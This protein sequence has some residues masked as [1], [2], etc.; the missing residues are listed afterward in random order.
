M[1][2]VTLFLLGFFCSMAM[3]AGEVTKLE[4]IQVAQQYVIQTSPHQGKATVGSSDVVYTQMMPGTDSAA[5]YIVNVGDNA[6]VLV[7]AD[8]VAQQV[9]GYS[10]N[11]NF[12]VKA[13]GSIELP[14]HIKGFLE[15]LA[16][17]VK[18]AVNDSGRTKA[19]VRQASRRAA[20]L[21]ESVDPLIT[22]TWDQGQYYN[23]L[24][25]LCTRL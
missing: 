20:N 17:Q 19:V 22:T 13:D 25:Y 24:S 21:P 2:K 14:A 12:P 3:L 11:R 4:A 10:F 16:T 23:V 8:D 9:L 6:F 1:R 18:V 7:S 15:D 5:F